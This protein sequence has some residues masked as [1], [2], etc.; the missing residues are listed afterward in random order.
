MTGE[1]A[2]AGGFS[3]SRGSPALHGLPFG[4]SWG[5]IPGNERTRKKSFLAFIYIPLSQASVTASASLLV[6]L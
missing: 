3:L 2:G 6:G 5:M 4:Q 1:E